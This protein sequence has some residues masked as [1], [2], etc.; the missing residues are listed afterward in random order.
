MADMRKCSENCAQSATQKRKRGECEGNEK[1]FIGKWERRLQSH[2]LHSHFSQISVRAKAAKSLRRL[3]RSKMASG[4]S[5]GTRLFR[6]CGT[7]LDSLKSATGASYSSAA[8]T[9]HKSAASKPKAKLKA[10][11]ATSTESGA[12]KE[13]NRSSGIF[14]PVQVSPAL[15]SFLGMSETSRSEAVKQI[16]SY[17]KLNNLQVTSLSLLFFLI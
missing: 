4:L 5:N 15:G 11:A 3:P 17:I 16:W 8:S 10:S 12:K 7:L 6:A 1:G 13:V 14:K 9:S 2:K